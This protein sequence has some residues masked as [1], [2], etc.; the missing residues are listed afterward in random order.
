MTRPSPD[1]VLADA[2]PQSTTV[3]VRHLRQI[4]L[5]PLRLMPLR[6]N[7]AAGAP[8]HT[9]WQALRELGDASPWREVVD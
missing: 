3:A 8:R 4:L 9:P 5:W 1:A 2:A 6:S 7:A